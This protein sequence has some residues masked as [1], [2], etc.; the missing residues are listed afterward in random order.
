MPKVLRGKLCAIF[1]FLVVF[2]FKVSAQVG[3]GSFS[4]APQ[5]SGG[6]TS[7]EPGSLCLNDPI[8]IPATIDIKAIN[9]AD[10]TNPN[11]FA[12]VID[13]DDGSALQTITYGGA[14]PI[15]YTAATHEYFIDNIPHVF[16]PKPCNA[17]MGRQC[18]YKP[19][20]YLRIAGV[21]CPAEFGNPPDFF[22]YNTDDQCSGNMVLSET[23][24]GAAIYE[25]CAGATTNVTF[26]DRTIINCLPPQEL[27]GLNSTRRWRRFTYG[28]FSDIT[29]GGPT[30]QVL[31]NGTNVGFPFMPTTTPD[32]SANNLATS[33]APFGNNN[34]LSITIPATA[35]VGEEFHI[36]MEYWNVC[37]VYD[38]GAGAPPPNGDRPSVFR[39]GII[40]I[41]G[42]P[43]APTP[44]DQVVCNNIGGSLPNFVVAFTASSSRVFWFRDNNGVK[45]TSITNPNGNN[46]KTFPVSA[47]PGGINKSTPGVYRLWARYRSRVN[48]AGLF[49][50]S[51]DVPVTLT[52]RP[53]I[54]DPIFSAGT[55]TVCNGTN[56]V[57]YSL[58]IPANALTAP[59]PGN[60]AVSFSTEYF[61]SASVGGVTITSTNPG[62]N[63]TAQNATV[64][65][66][67]PDATFGVGNSINVD[68]QV[69]RRYTSNSTFPA[70]GSNC[71]S[72]VVTFPVTVYRNTSPGS[73]AGGATKCQGEDLGPITWTPGI[74]TIQLWEISSNGGGSWS[75]IPGFGTSTTVN[76]NTLG[77]LH[78][79]APAV[80]T[81]YLIRAQVKNGNCPTL[82]TGAVTFLINENADPA[83]AG[84]DQGL[85][86]ILTTSLAATNATGTWSVV[87][88]NGGNV[89]G[90]SVSNPT[91]IFTVNTPGIY[92]LM[93]TTSNGTCT[94][95]D[96]VLITF[97]Q[98]AGVPAPVSNIFCGKTGTLSAAAPT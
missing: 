24:T 41:V 92:E 6:I 62:Q 4:G 20:I 32:V 29:E 11:N 36:R 82:P 51:I 33:A 93:W 5:P 78:T 7:D 76:P 65:F 15:T 54:P 3:C 84:A 48:S 67:I 50:E 13:W 37:N 12:V 10:G 58:Q 46:N 43:A 44:Q 34:T 1:V 30:D 63:A 35:Q 55:S 39:D 21:T 52:I 2:S 38:D 73:L 19:R 42:Q 28:T 26:T 90:L 83:A 75:T 23:L 40:R 16:L 81:E 56:G 59:N 17:T 25:V 95:Q 69:V 89:T 66:N 8:Q 96:N 79:G 61:W 9:V 98:V 57:A 68:I 94:S 85:C 86:G 27:T 64:D 77:L 22:R 87:S 18:A 14:T 88:G 71:P 45:G 74:G 97:G 47:Y 80:P 49:C 70:P 72:N 31:I 53:A 60:P 91:S